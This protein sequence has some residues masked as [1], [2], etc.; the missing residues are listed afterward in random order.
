M[1]RPN[2][3]GRQALRSKSGCDRPV[4]GVHCPEPSCFRRAIGIGFA[5]KPHPGTRP[6][7]HG[8]GGH[9]STQ[10]IPEQLRPETPTMFRAVEGQ[11]GEEDGQDHARAAATDARWHRLL[12]HQMGGKAEVGHDRA[13]RGPARRTSDRCSS[14]WR[15]ARDR[16]TSGRGQRC[17]NRSG[18]GRGAPGAPL[19]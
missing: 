4:V 14:R 7:E 9:R 18:S 19:R 10:R 16:A 8:R 13:R 17:R 12:A 6:L 11:T 2:W 15:G 1:P 3:A 5:S